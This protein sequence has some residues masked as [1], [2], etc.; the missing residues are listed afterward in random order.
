MTQALRVKLFE[1][2]LRKNIGWFDNKNRAPGVL[3]NMISEDI[4]AINGLTTE[5][6]GI[7]CEAFLGLALS[8]L[9]CFYFSWR[10][11]L[12]VTVTCPFMVLGGL[13]M[14]RL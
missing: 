13:G 3:V 2:L 10:L 5:V 4:T 12:V 14:S 7:A 9:V 11:A 6:A 1:S 8:C